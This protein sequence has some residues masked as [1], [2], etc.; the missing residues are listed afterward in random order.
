MMN[1]GIKVL[2]LVTI[3]AAFVLGY[4]INSTTVPNQNSTSQI[5]EQTK[6]KDSNTQ[7]E[8]N[9]PLKVSTKR[10][11]SNATVMIKTD[12]NKL[13][14]NLE[15]LLSGG[16]FSLDMASIA[17]AYNLIE[18]LT[19][20]ELLT[21][22]N[23]MK[24]NL[25]KPSNL[26][27][28]SL[29]AGRLATFDPLKAANFID[30]NINSPQAKMTAMMSVISS[31]GK[32]DPISA[33]YWYIDPNNSYAS[34]NTFSSM[35]L[36]SIFN[37][38]AANDI[39]DA[40]TKLTELDI[41]GVNTRMAAMG[42]SQ[43]LESKV[44]F[45]QFIVRSDEL[46]NINIKDS[47][48]SSWVLKN[49]L[50]TI[51]WS[52]SIAEKEKQQ[53]VQS[54]I[55]LNWSSA[56]PRNAANW[57]IETASESEKQLKATKIIDMWGMR[58]PSAALEWLDQQTG[59]DTQKSIIKL[60]D[61]SAYLNTQFAVDNLQRLTSDKAKAD[62][63]YR[64]YQSLMRSSTKKAA[65]FLSSSPYTKEVE[66]KKMNFDKYMEKKSTAN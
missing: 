57:Y 51:E 32:K 7:T 13:R 25:N 43:T 59:F 46:D 56:E 36:L 48:I 50:E 12:L 42:I 35:G 14:N 4:T 10:E 54:T 9:V 29:L 34:E 3:G 21:T 60:L 49:P 62:V 30:D 17:Q 61:S 39:N 44:D 16:Q 66:K 47:I 64:I 55:Y 58:E 5:V 6:L 20:D 33:Y 1:N 18:S 53:K 24:G 63:S 26:Q 52:E 22:L 2:W 38:L 40:Y 37:G 27:I 45:I 15:N 31:W 41:S 28:L 11:K 23:L 8:N 65:E 19:E